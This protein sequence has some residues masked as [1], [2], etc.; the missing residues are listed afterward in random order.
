MYITSVSIY[1][2]N[3]LG[4]YDTE[5]IGYRKEAETLEDAKDI[6]DILWQAAELDLPDK[7]TVNVSTLTYTDKDEY[8]DCDDFEIKF[9]C[10]RTTEPSKFIKWG[11]KKP[12]IFGIDRAHSRMG[13]AW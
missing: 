6:T 10:K 3:I 8:I 2:K 7:C 9:D 12:H 5:P 11:D 1:E 13:L 4:K